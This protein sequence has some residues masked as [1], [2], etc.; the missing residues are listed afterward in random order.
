MNT[1]THDT[2]T[3]TGTDGIA[4]DRNVPAGTGELIVELD[5]LLSILARIEYASNRNCRT[6]DEA[7]RLLNRIVTT[8]SE[9][10]T[11]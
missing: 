1:T 2:L 4:R 7:T 10:S 3:M 6:A 9:G 8:L 11:R 5:G